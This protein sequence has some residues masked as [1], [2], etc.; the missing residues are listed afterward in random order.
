[1]VITIVWVKGGRNQIKALAVWTKK[2]IRNEDR[3]DLV[4][5]SLCKLEI[6]I[7]EKLA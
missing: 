3:K 1:M 5:F 6:R 7:K 4:I 2:V